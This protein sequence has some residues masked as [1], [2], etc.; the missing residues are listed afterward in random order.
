MKIGRAN[1]AARQVMA[2]RKP[3]AVTLDATG[4]VKVGMVE[5]ATDEDLIGVYRYT[6][7]LETS[8]E[9]AVDLTQAAVER[10]LHRE[11]A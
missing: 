1:A 7:L 4:N 6:G 2:S 10:G 5:S 9:I 3:S 8:R 11:A